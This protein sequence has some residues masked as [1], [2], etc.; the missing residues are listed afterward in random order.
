THTLLTPGPSPP[1][2]RGDVPP[3]PGGRGGGG[4][5]M[6]CI[7]PAT[8][9]HPPHPQPLAPEGR[10]PEN[11]QPQPDRVSD[12]RSALPTR[13]PQNAS[14]TAETELMPEPGRSWL[15]GSNLG[16]PDGSGLPPPGSG[17]LPRSTIA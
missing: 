10:G 16:A 2:A 8:N 3:R 12:K 6:D 14:R 1:G 4:G 15:L 11:G 5:G 9:T 17:S 13:P 7:A